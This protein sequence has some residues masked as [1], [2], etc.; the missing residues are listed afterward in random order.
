MQWLKAFIAGFVA[1]LVFHQGVFALLY[2]A[3]AVPVAPFNLTPVGPLGVPQVVSLAFFGGLW[4]LPAWALI[5]NRGRALYWGIATVFGAIAPTAVAMLV[6]FPMKGLDVELATW[7][8]GGIL[9]GAWGIGVA[10][11]MV[12]LGGKGKTIDDF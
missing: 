9:N 7:I 8:G 3:E 12:L 5:R 11:I 10:L 2:L 6:V 4:G 1:T